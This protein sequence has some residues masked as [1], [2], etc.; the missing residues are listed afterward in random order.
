MTNSQYSANDDSSAQQSPEFHLSS[1]K[2]L[3]ISLVENIPA[4]FVRKDREGKFLY[5]NDMFAA[6]LGVPADQIIGRTV[7]DFYS[8]ELAKESKEEDEAVMNSGQVVEDVFDA[9]IRG[10][11][12]YFASR[13]GPVRNDRKEVVGI[14]TIIWDITEQ[15]LAEI[16]LEA[17]REELRAARVAA[18]QANRAKSDFLANMSHEIRTPMNAIIGITDLLMETP[19]DNVQ[20]EYLR[21]IQDSGDSLLGLLNDILDFSKIEA[22]KLELEHLPFDIRE[23]IGDTLK[24]LSFRAQSKGLE[25]VCRLAPDIPHRVIGD[26]NRLRQ[27]VINLVGNAIKFTEIGEVL[28]EA[29]CIERTNDFVTLRMAVSDTGIGIGP[30]SLE[31]IFREFEQADASTTRKYGGTGLGLAICSR[32]VQLMGGSISVESSI[33]V[34]SK[35]QIAIALPIDCCDQER[36]KATHPEFQGVRVLVVD[37]NSTN[38]KILKEM[39]VSWGLNPTTT[40]DGESALKA[41]ADARH[42]DDSFDLVISDLNMPEMDGL[43]LVESILKRAYLTPQAIIMLTSGARPWQS[44]QLNELGVAAQLLKPAKQSEIYDAIVGSLLRSPDDTFLAQSQPSNL[45]AFQ[46]DE[47]HSLRVL[48]AEDNQVNQ[49]LAIGILENLGHSV[50]VAAT[51]REALQKLSEADYDVVLMDVQMPVMDG[52]E[53]TR[54]IRRLEMVTGRHVPV[55]AMTAHAMKGDRENCLAAGMDDYMSKPIRTRD[56]QAKLE[57][58]L[59]KT[60][61]ITSLGATQTVSPPVQ[62]S[63]SED[64]VSWCAALENMAG[65]QELFSQVLQI[66]LEESKQLMQ[67]LE[68][69]VVQLDRPCIASAAHSIKGSLAFLATNKTESAFADLESSAHTA[70][71]KELQLKFLNCSTLMAMVSAAIVHHL[72]ME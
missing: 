21:M 63:K 23:S 26:S 29:D 71:Q 8:Q 7:A 18:E 47:T 24:G 53:T 60:S 72:S 5:V 35:F 49:K 39:L 59:R 31:R 57:Q 1:E 48:L 51:G 30:Q 38:R 68:A 22:G 16:A 56:I 42:E 17:E 13:K 25:L 32:L 65:N 6:M 14:Q 36:Q 2:S 4:C 61:A 9:A 45:F 34:G 19:L 12:R 28:L 3:F 20:R 44:T 10:E 54:E 62:E 41:L 27:I 67:K 40:S 69:A 50:T 66:F 33:G 46:R 43:T 64:D 55:I 15:R 58:F 11:K 70:S 37:D 52:L